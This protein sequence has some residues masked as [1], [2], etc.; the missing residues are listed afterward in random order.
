ML[1]GGAVFEVTNLDQAKTAES[2]VPCCVVISNP[3][4]KPGISCMPDLSLIKEIKQALYLRNGKIKG[5]ASRRGA[6]PRVNRRRS[7]RRERGSCN[8]RRGSLHQ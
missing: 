8:H 1:R 7:H 2:A 6:D 5:W 4:R 3:P